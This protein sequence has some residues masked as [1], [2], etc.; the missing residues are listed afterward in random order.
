MV[1][2]FQVQ[3]FEWSLICDEFFVVKLELFSKIVNDCEYKLPP[4]SKMSD[5]LNLVL[6]LFLVVTSF[7]V[8]LQ[9]RRDSSFYLCG[10]VSQ[11]LSS[12]CSRIYTPDTAPLANAWFLLLRFQTSEA[13]FLPE[14][15][16]L[17][18]LKMASKVTAASRARAEGLHFGKKTER[19]AILASAETAKT[20]FIKDSQQY[21]QLTINGVLQRTG[22]ST[23]LVK[24]LA[25]FDP[26][27]MLK[28]PMDVALRHFEVLYSTFALRSWVDESNESQCRHQY[29][30]LLDH[31]RT[32]YGPNF[33]ITSIAADLIEFLMGLEFLHERSH[34][35]YL[36]KLSCLCT[37][38]T[39]PNYPDVVFG[40]VT[41]AGGQSRFTD[42]ILPCQSYMANVPCSVIRSSEE[43][44]LARFSSLTASFGRTAFSSDYD[45][46]T[47]VDTFGRSK[48]YKSLLAT[49]R[50][51]DSAPK[52]VTVQE[53]LEDSCT[54]G[55]QSAVKLP[56]SKKRKRGRSGSRST[57]SSVVGSP[58]KDSSSKA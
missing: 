56:S 32:A 57:T 21:I 19:S 5:I 27:I 6:V 1:D 43:S 20:D 50:K 34:L 12:L 9:C 2:P 18:R 11:F 37:T 13:T 24:G 52:R 41:T 31:L 47:H 15:E 16:Y 7:T 35:L 29:I 26:F 58:S 45:P 10:E 23:N 36:F 54:V 25:A 53:D 30:Q 40:E 51:S 38:A 44:N 33:D 48:M 46:W 28:R 55:D 42:L 49:Y 17:I 4:C 14:D 39:S 3:S 8:S 22:L